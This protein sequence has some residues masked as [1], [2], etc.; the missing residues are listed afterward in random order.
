ML[1]KKTN[2]PVTI[3]DL[4]NGSFRGYCNLSFLKLRRGVACRPEVCIYRLTLT[5][6]GLMIVACSFRF[7]ERLV[8]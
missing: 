2:C 6:P 3:N 7:D 5:T 1:L 4:K 8:T